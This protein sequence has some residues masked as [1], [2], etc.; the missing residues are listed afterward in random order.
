MKKKLISYFS[1]IVY[2][3]SKQFARVSFAHFGR[4][5]DAYDNALF[6]F[7][8]S[9]ESVILVSKFQ[10]TFESMKRYSFKKYWFVEL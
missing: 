8:Y 2:S 5:F 6:E 9:T 7:L 1:H 4:V 3:K 10:Y